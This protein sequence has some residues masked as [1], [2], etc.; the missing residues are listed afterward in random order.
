VEAFAN[1]Y[2]DLAEIVAAQLIGEAP[3]PLALT[4]PTATDGVAGLDFVE[5]CERAPARSIPRG[6]G[7]FTLPGLLKISLR[8]SDS[9][10]ARLRAV[11]VAHKAPLVA[12]ATTV[13]L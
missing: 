1:I 12:I 10:L 2:S 4:Y 9:S 5:S 13:L 11:D 7:E 3:D 6:V 8:K